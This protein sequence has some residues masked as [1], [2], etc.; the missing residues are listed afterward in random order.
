MSDPQLPAYS[1]AA[2][3]PKCTCQYIAGQYLATQPQLSWSLDELA[4]VSTAAGFGGECMLRTCHDCGYAWL[5]Q[6][7]DARSAA[8]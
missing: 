1:G 6:T 4:L 5:E 3:C 2:T 8:G 7:A